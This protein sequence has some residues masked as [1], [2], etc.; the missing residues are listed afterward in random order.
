VQR[1][2]LAV[3]GGFT[4]RDG[5]VGR[6]PDIFLFYVYGRSYEDRTPVVARSCRGGD[7][8]ACWSQF[9]YPLM[10]VNPGASQQTA[11]GWALFISFVVVA[12]V[13]VACRLSL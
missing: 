1:T 5:L 12:G 7:V 3:I 2:L 10:D 13:A 6:Y 9:F 11:L 4:V 8:A